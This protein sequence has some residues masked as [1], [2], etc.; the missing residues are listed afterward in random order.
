MIVKNMICE[1]CACCSKPIRAGH[2]F[3]TCNK[4]DSIIHKKCKT[5][6]N[7][8][9]FRDKTYCSN[10]INNHDIIRYNPF[11]H[12]PHF[13][14]NDFLDSEPQDYIESIDTIS[15]TLE[16]CQTLSTPQFNHLMAHSSHTKKG[17]IFSSYF[18]NIDG[19]STN[20]DNLVLDLARIDH[21]FSVIGLAET[22]T[23]PCNGQLYQLQNYTSC[24]QH[25]FFCDKKHLSKSKGS[26]V[27]LYVHNSL[28]FSVINKLS[29]CTEQLE[30][31][32]IKISNVS[33]PLT[34]GV[35]YLSLIH[36]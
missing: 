28:N 2:P 7:I 22:N 12:A 17:N 13:A 4:C 9:T 5:R 27:C 34:I 6:D 3:I 23:D 26:G 1:N 29:F 32:F 18:R 21:K 30:S 11:Y 19:N 33:E 8:S 36:I 15:S 25:R 10:C 16:N 20:F 31:L 24:Y 14:N 35:I